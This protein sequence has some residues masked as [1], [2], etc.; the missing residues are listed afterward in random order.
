MYIIKS[1]EGYLRIPK[2]A[3]A[4]VTSM[5]KASVYTD[6]EKC[7]ALL[8]AAAHE[9]T[10]SCLRIAEIRITEKDHIFPPFSSEL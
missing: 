7:R 1:D 6:F 9:V 8:E 4:E 10:F 5:E 2:D 3:P